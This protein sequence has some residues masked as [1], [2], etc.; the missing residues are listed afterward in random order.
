[1]LNIF[2]LTMKK[3][4]LSVALF[5]VFIMPVAQAAF[6]DDFEGVVWLD[7]NVSNWPETAQ[8]TVDV[9]PQ[10]VILNSSKKDVWPARGNPILGLNNPCCNANAWVFA[11]FGGTWYAVTW[12]WLKK[13]QSAK[14]LS[15]FE[16]GHTR[17]FPFVGGGNP[18]W[19]PVN[20]VVYGLM[21]SGFA[22][23]NIPANIAERSNIVFYRWGQ[24]P[25]EVCD[26]FPDSEGCKSA[27]VP[28]NSVM[29]LLFDDETP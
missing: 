16:G 13:G 6:P 20:G 7:T 23:Y 19:R 3:I 11:E 5:S 24:G 1:M 15:A 18:T 10:F 21:V 22:R 17:R 27:P 12:E 29:D 28:M 26:A 9:T 8:L 4:I 14:N 2:R 25:V